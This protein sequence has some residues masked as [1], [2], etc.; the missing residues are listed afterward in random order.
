[1][2]SY[3][4]C[5]SRR[6]LRGRHTRL[7]RN[8]LP[9]NARRGTARV[10]SKMIAFHAAHAL[11]TPSG[12]GFC[13]RSC[14]LRIGSAPEGG[15]GVAA[16][17]PRPAPTRGRRHAA[18]RLRQPG[19]ARRSFVRAA[20][21]CRASR[22]DSPMACSNPTP[23]SGADP[24]GGMSGLRCVRSQ[25]RRVGPVRRAISASMACSNLRLECRY[26]SVDQCDQSP[27]A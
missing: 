1:M 14:W 24:A 15:V 18:S 20:R 21:Q 6:R 7:Q 16:R 23:P 5:C 9:T 13:A 12:S 17:S 22:P 25:S 11:V 27:G 3:R 8:G 2:C 19:A 10:R 4:R 26:F